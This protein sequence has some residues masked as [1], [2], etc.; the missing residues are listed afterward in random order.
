MLALGCLHCEQY[1]D[2]CASPPQQRLLWKRCNMNG[3]IPLAGAQALPSGVPPRRL[4]RL[5]VAVPGL[6]IA[7]INPGLA[8]ADLKPIG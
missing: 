3:E 7:Q 2:R 8:V 6:L 4:K 5:A 1:Q